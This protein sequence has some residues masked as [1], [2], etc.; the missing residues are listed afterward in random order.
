LI[1]VDSRTE[2]QFFCVDAPPG[3]IWNGIDQQTT[4]VPQKVMF[5]RLSHPDAKVFS[6]NDISVFPKT[7]S[8]FLFQPSHDQRSN[9]E[10]RQGLLQR[11]IKQPTMYLFA[12]VDRRLAIIGLLGIGI[13]GENVP[14][15]SN[16]FSCF[17]ASESSFRHGEKID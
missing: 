11:D 2:N 4:I 10:L 15:V 9:L 14:L 1:I 13:P 17:S 16:K 8:A 3:Y 5:D 6:S 7:F 12:Q